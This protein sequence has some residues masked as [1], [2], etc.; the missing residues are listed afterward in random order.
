MYSISKT[1]DIF[2][3]NRYLFFLSIVTAASSLVSHFCFRTE[4]KKNIPC[5][6]CLKSQGQSVKNKKYTFH[7]THFH[8]CLCFPSNY[9]PTEMKRQKYFPNTLQLYV[10]KKKVSSFCLLHIKSMKCD[11]DVSFSKV[12][13]GIKT[14]FFNFIKHSGQ[15]NGFLSIV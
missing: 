6:T 9:N 10:Q 4:T 7:G 13:P 15:T 3:L 5:Q 12:D 1:L 11:K 2:L 14:K 8:V